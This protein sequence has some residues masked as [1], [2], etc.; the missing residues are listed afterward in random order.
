MK[1]ERC[2]KNLACV[3]VDEMINGK[4]EQ[5]YLCQSCV[6]ELLTTMGQVGGLGKQETPTSKKISHDPH[7]DEALQQLFE[8]VGNEEVGHIQASAMLS[9][10]IDQLAES[11]QM[12]L[13]QQA[14]LR[15][16]YETL[17]R[18]SLAGKKPS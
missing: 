4:R 9:S 8:E 7:L 6:D 12:T 18:R 1:C 10:F 2:Q 15:G 11:P 13:E 17:V 3:R 5:H 16:I 14:L